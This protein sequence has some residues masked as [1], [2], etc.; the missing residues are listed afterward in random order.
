[1]AEERPALADAVTHESVSLKFERR[2]K[3]TYRVVFQFDVI[4]RNGKRQ[5]ETI[6]SDWKPRSKIY[7]TAA[8]YHKKMS[9]FLFAGM[10]PIPRP[11]KVAG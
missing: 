3:S 5:K 7:A 11:A 1:M 2:G 10:G 8:M 6:K 9:N 4:D